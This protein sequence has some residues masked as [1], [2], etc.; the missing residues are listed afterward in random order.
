MH[1]EGLPLKYL[2]TLYW[3]SQ[4]NQILELS[5][6]AKVYG[7]DL[8]EDL[9]DMFQVSDV[10]A[11]AY[12]EIWVT[13]EYSTFDT[14]EFWEDR[15]SR[16]NVYSSGFPIAQRVAAQT[17]G[18]ELVAVQPMTLPTGL[19]QYMDYQYETQS[20]MT[21][22]MGIPAERLGQVHHEVRELG[23]SAQQAT[24]AMRTLGS[25]MMDA[26]YVYAPYIPLTTT[27]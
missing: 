17:L 14:I 12:I 3:V 8:V 10:V 1:M 11:T 4:N 13:D 2:S 7:E 6:D 23:V 18:Q 27:P 16:Y 25:T 21:Q 20:A 26:G 9:V 19:L 15:R 22:A 5:N 24:T